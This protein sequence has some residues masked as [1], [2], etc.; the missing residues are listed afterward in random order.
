[1]K[2]I[3]VLILTIF[4]VVTISAQAEVVTPY[5]GTRIFWDLISRSTVFTNGWYSRMVELKDGRLMAACESNGIS[6]AYSSNKGL[7]WTAATKLTSNTNNTPNC[8]PDLIQLK[9]GTIIVAYNPRPSQPYTPDRHYGIRCKR[10]TD[11]GV[12][13][14]DEIVVYNASYI[15]DDGCW[16]PSMLELPSGELQLYF[17]N[18]A[19]YTTSG[20]QEISM[21]KSFDGGLTWTAAQR[22]SYRAGYRDGMPVPVLLKDQSEIAVIIEDNGWPGVGD[23]FPTTVRCP[24]STNWNNYYVAANSTNRNKTLDFTY[25]PNATGGAPYLRVLPSGKTV[26]SYQSTYNHGT[27]LSMLVAVG[28]E[29]AKNFKALQHPF[30]VGDTDAVMWNSLCVIDTG[31]VVA[32]GGVNNNI[33]MIKGYPCDKLQANFSHPTIDGVQTKNEGYY[34]PLANQIMLGVESGTRTIADFAYDSDSLYF[35]S[36]VSDRT[37][38]AIA[39]SYCDGI[40]LLLDVKNRSGLAP[41]NDMYRLFFRLEGTYNLWHGDDTQLKWIATDANN[42]NYKVTAKSTYYVVEAAIPWTVLGCDAPPTNEVL[43]ANIELQD[44][45][46]DDITTIAKETIVDASRDK[47]STWMELYLNPNNTPSSIKNTKE[48]D[49]I[50]YIK[51]G[52]N[53]RIYV[54]SDTNI[55]QLMLCSVNGMVL[56]TYDN[57]GK[58]FET[59]ISQ[60]GVVV[61]KGN[62]I[63]GKTFIKKVCL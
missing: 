48:V 16:E 8:V 22:I 49:E 36:R 27:K 43:R 45:N 39:G 15:W 17:A 40:S 6:I 24:L 26:M 2:A 55:E 18:E 9:D 12:T 38:Y 53:G 33:E 63:N 23:F 42:I 29:K 30:K 19:P 61:V 57:I 7:A 50:A 34:Q 52:N 5:N 31:I 41:L 14:S 56:N 10:S 60:K 46:S 3:K 25:C 11:N 20:E 13:W 59:N 1:M 4:T 54:T 35:T 32:V 47:S 62:F 37:P 58:N 51:V 44:R 28:D 21:C